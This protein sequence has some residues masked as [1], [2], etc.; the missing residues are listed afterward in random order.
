MQPSLACLDLPC[1]VQ[2]REILGKMSDTR[3]TLLFSATLPRKLADFASAGL[4]A[5]QLVQLD[6]ERRMSPD[7]ATLFFTVRQ[8]DKVP[9]LLYLVRELLKPEQ[10]TI[11]F[12]ATRHHVEY[13]GALMIREEIPAACVY[14]SM[15]QVSVGL[16]GQSGTG[17]INDVHD[18]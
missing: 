9:A 1:P 10:L 13:L 5:P 3:Q 8:E 17:A 11:I 6:V 2:I 7:L 14:G 4:N 15:D 18:L 12:A 16:Q